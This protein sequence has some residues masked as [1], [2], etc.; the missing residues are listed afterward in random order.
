MAA[1][2][3]DI[4]FLVDKSSFPQNCWELDDFL[5]VLEEYYYIEFIDIDNPTAFYKYA[6]KE[7][8][9]GK[10]ELVI[11]VTRNFYVRDKLRMEGVGLVVCL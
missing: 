2:N 3:E 10:Y 9:S 6:L 11:P 5:D 7:A 4:L 8:Q 1:K